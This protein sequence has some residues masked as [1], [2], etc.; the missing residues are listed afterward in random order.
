MVRRRL[1][2]HYA[3]LWVEGEITDLARPRSGHIYFSLRDDEDDAALRAVMWASDARRLT[4][5]PAEGQRVRARGTLTL[6]EA[7]GS[8]QMRVARLV[9][10]GDG[11]LRRRF[12]MVRARL[13]AQGLL[14]ESRKRPLPPAPRRVGVV[15]SRDGAALRDIL[16]VLADRVPLSVL[17]VHAAVQ[18]ETAPGEIVAALKM[19]SQVP[20]VEV[21]IAG[22]GGGAADELSAWNDES[23]AMAM[24]AHPVPVI[25]AVG[26]Q[27]DVTIAD[28]VADCRAATPTEAAML[29]VPARAEAVKSITQLTTRLRRAM[30]RRLSVER[31]GYVALRGR[32]PEG[33][34]LLDG[35]R[36]KADEQVRR[37]EEAL[38][39]QVSR[40]RRLHQE[41]QLRL[42]RLHPRARIERRRAVW[43][44]TSLRLRHWMSRESERRR[45]HLGRLVARLDSLSPLH[46]LSRGYAAVRSPTGEVVTRAEQVEVGDD[47][48]VH[49]RQGKLDC[50]VTGRE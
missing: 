3:N 50:T 30:P 7:R 23:V 22:R 1:E 9:E 2:G 34:R 32:L 8:F 10:A 5:K 14:D 42:V 6:Y 29:I 28:L 15:T 24:A 18:G 31:A 26:H 16:K 38:R 4:F 21:V 27:T 33:W 37:L 39:G 13:Q 49:L 35:P 12:E 25:S 11:E 47:I 19:L 43:S 46:V 48:A 36:Q 40:R 45:S 44:A 41:V 20:S 17:L